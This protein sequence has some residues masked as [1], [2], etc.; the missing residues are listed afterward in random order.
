MIAPLEQIAASVEAVPVA[1][2]LSIE[3]KVRLRQ[4]ERQV[5]KNL[6]AFIQCGRALL[7]IRSSK[8]FR[9]RYAT[10]EAYC[11]ERFALA[12]SS[13]DQLIRSASTAQLL[14]D[15]G[16]DMP[17]NASEAVVRPVSTL[18]SPELQVQAWRLV[19]AVS[20]ERGPSQ[21]IA[22][23]VVRVIKNAIESPGTNGKG[24]K[25]RSRAHPSRERP[26]VQ[27]AQRLGS[28][29]GFSPEI[30]TSHIEKL[31]SA[32]SVYTACGKLAERCQ[33]VRER[34]AERFPELVSTDA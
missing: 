24:H 23:K 31:P 19:Q 8:L 15:S 5:E 34:L 21:P 4:L 17:D 14:I 16:V 1:Q 3:E 13:C 25:P 28:Y 7:E 18:S 22:S 27:A 30:V 2:P 9:D 32:W 11:R 12:R 26:F 33:L 29:A 10:F 6:S 20:P